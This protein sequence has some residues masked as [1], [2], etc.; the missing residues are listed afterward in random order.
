MVDISANIP[1]LVRSGVSGHGHGHRA[2]TL[3]Q[4]VPETTVSRVYMSSLAHPSTMTQPMV[5]L[6]KVITLPLIGAEPHSI[7]LTLPPTSKISY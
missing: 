5:A 1:N 7:S 4:P 6:M 3:G 2:H